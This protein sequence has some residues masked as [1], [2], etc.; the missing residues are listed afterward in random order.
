MNNFKYDV[1]F[2]I[3]HPNM[4]PKDICKK[5]NM[6][7]TRMWCAGDQRKTPKG[8]SLPS[9]Y[10]HSYCSFKL[11]QTEYTELIDLL[12]SWNKKLLNFKTFLNKIHSSGGKL[13]YFIGWYSKES[14]GEEFDVSL[15]YELV[16]LKINLAID[17]YCG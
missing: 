2:R 14:S 6:Q 5:L 9:V 13:E 17:F 8:T 16:E 15:M 1:S 11:D 7:A 4:N 10:E 3:F 12:K